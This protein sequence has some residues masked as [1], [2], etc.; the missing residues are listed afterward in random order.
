[1]RMTPII[2]GMAGMVAC[3][4]V[5]AMATGAMSNPSTR[6]AVKNSAKN[7]SHAAK[8]AAHDISNSMMG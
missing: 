2:T 3:A 4:V 7:M 6:R 8:K 5:S 1:M